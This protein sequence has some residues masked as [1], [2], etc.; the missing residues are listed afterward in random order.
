MA[1]R[2]FAVVCSWV[3]VVGIAST[4]VAQALPGTEPLTIAEPLDEVMVDGID[5]FAL[6]ALADSVA[7]RAAHW[8]RVYSS[9]A[10][11]LKSVAKNRA[12]FRTIIGAVDERPQPQGI[13]L[14]ASTTD[15]AVVAETDT[16][17]ILAVRWPA[18]PGVYG[19][20]LL[21]QPK[22]KPLARVIALPDADWTPE[23]FIGLAEG[24]D[25][26]A[27]SPLQLVASSCQVL[28]PTLISRAD[29]FSG[30]PDIRMTNQTHREWIYRQAFEMGRHVIGYEVQKV[31]AA[32]D[33]FERLNEMENGDLPI[34]V[35]GVGEGGLLALHSG[36]AD[37]RI[38]AVLV[39][40]YFEARE[41][42]WQEPIYRNVWSQLSEFGDAEL[43]GLIAP[44][45]LTI[46]AAAV[47]EVAGPPQPTAGRS[48]GAA[49]GAIEICTLGHVRKEVDRA[50]V[51][52]DKLKAT[53]KFYFTSSREGDGPSGTPA[54]LAPFLKG[55]SIEKLNPP[56]AAA[57][58]DRRR[59][60]DP[61]ARQQRQVAQL[62]EFTQELSRRS[63]GVRD[64]FWSKADRS[65]VDSWEKTAEFYRQ[66]IWD[67]LIGKIPPPDMPL[68]PRTRQIFDTPG[69]T[70]YEVVLDV[71]P[72]VIAAGILL[73]PKNLKEGEKRPVVVCQ[74]G[75][76]GVPMDT[77]TQ[78]GRGFKY[79]SAYAHELA[80]RGFI[81]YAPQN[82][83]RGKDRFRVLQR[84]SNPV[85]RSLF[86][87][88]L[89]Q[90]ER[91]LEFLAGLPNVDPQ[92]IGFYGLSYGGKTA[93]RVP[94]LL[95]GYALSICSADYDEWIL[96]NTSVSDRYSYM[97]TGEYEM[98]EWNMGHV[99]NYAELASLMAPRPFM[100]E[101]GHYDGVAPDEWV[102]WEY[103]KVRRHYAELDIPEKTEI[104]Y[105]KGP[106]SINGVGTFEFLHRHL[107][108]PKD[109]E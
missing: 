27:R 11:Y 82:P 47:P 3:I 2:L 35:L 77:I 9:E 87:Y 105:F 93:V 58:A 63:S 16:Y 29:T 40:G 32:V 49:P 91:T 101:R 19:E 24:V 34:G 76:E 45:S 71:Y 89:R 72:D 43:A 37:T 98:F 69:Y 59:L 95:P 53:D 103:A 70:G 73:L 102:A 36:A 31:M 50:A 86:S 64:K 13:E 20:G 7:G 85:K 106:H 4:A 42:V 109:H 79:Y 55:L 104:E 23:M 108:W 15:A 78:E 107:N 41:N 54:A 5:R 60:F 88:I 83:Y 75:L 52:Y 66:Y 44:R 62:V 68:H 100:V 65:S 61:Q 81:T 18:L 80:N 57:T 17:Q 26:P 22:S 74:H 92:R 6:R 12:A 51:H 94:P 28:I 30:N 46:E 96:K 21:L 56:A 14:I 10:A 39:S 90:H 97:F 25:V 67:E 99:A 38:E 33:Q 48:S 84:K 8:N 1:F